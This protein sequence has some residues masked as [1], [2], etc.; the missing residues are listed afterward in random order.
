MKLTWLESP[1]IALQDAGA[2]W[3]TFSGPTGCNLVPWIL[4]NNDRDQNYST[5]GQIWGKYQ[6]YWLVLVSLLLYNIMDIV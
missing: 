2:F 3:H 6:A 4:Y 1:R 5:K